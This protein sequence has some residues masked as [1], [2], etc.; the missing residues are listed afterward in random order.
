[1]IW[2]LDFPLRSSRLTI[3]CYEINSQYD[4]GHSPNILAL[5]GTRITHS[6]PGRRPSGT[7]QSTSPEFT[8]L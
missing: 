4:G 5:P 8:L 2:V 6:L 7:A 1:M 3:L